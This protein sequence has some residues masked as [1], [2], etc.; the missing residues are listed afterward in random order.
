VLS[1]VLVARLAAADT[2]YLKGGGKFEGKVV[3]EGDQV[4]VYLENGSKLPFPADRVERVERGPAPWEQ[5]AAKAA[6]LKAD[7]AA[8]HLEL[9]KWC[10]LKKLHKRAA[11]HLEAVVG[12]EPDNAEARAM[13]GHQKV[14]GKWMTKEEALKAKGYALVDGRW[15]SPEELAAREAK[16]KLEDAVKQERERLEQ[17]GDSD[18]EKAG[19]ARKFYLDR[20]GK[21]LKNLIWAVMNLGNSR[22]R[23]AAVKLINQIGTKD[24]RHS[25]W[26]SQTVLKEGNNDCVKELC[27]G[28]KARD[29][30]LAM[31][32]LVIMAA[33]ENVYRRKA[34]YCLSLL[35]DKR[36]YRA[37]IGCLAAQ[38]KGGLPGTA[39][40]NL[41]TLGNMAS[42][43]GGMGGTS[44]SGEEVVPA[45]DSLEYISGQNHRN[46]VKKWLE[47]LDSLDKAPGGAVVA[48][49]KR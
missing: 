10:G 9:A 13:L 33:N 36:C 20:G 15:L 48:P 22:A 26:L 43:V 49:A 25:V 34:A 16:K 47:W 44:I 14:G 28:F 6:A 32:Y 5:Y 4:I 8:G 1:T 39:G 21:S 18:P 3:I 40:M 42:N 45:A 12:I 24:K 41:G 2:V 35:N 7:D 11:K 19:A 37:L 23:L 17:L 27:K 30:D 31:T 38:G 29:D 46:D